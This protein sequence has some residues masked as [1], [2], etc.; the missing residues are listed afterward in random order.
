MARAILR[1]VLNWLRAYTAQMVAGIQPISVICNR[2]Q[3]SPAMGRPMVKKVSQGRKNA[4]KS[5]IRTSV[6][7]RIIA[8]APF[9]APAKS[10]QRQFALDT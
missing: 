3:I 2:R 6:P 9:Q 1:S 10:G 7:A 8:Q 4:I 5:R